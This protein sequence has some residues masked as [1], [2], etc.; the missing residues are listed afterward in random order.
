MAVSAFISQASML[1]YSNN[2]AFEIRCE[3]FKACLEKDATY[4]D[5]HSPAVMPSILETSLGDLK[6]GTGSAFSTFFMMI[7]TAVSGLIVGF[8]MEPK[9]AGIFFAFFPINLI[10]M[11]FVGVTI[12]GAIMKDQ[13]LSAKSNGYAQ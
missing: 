9:L 3:F 4:F 6:N 5:Y 1:F 11:T 12:I 10:I 13:K 8:I 2:N 7:S